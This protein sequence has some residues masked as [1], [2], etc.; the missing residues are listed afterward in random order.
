[1]MKIRT[2][3]FLALTMMVLAACGGEDTNQAETNLDTNELKDIMN[4]YTVDDLVDDAAAITSLELGVEEDNEEVVY[5]V[6][7]EEFCVAIAA[8]INETNEGA[9]HSLSGCQGVLDEED[10]DVMITYA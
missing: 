8:F 1:M 2:I 4:D 5:E 10:L 6:P 7:E 9:V 3:I